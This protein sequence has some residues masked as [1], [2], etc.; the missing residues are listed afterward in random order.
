MINFISEDDLKHILFV[1]KI[2]AEGG[3]MKAAKLLFQYVIGKP[4]ETVDPDRVDVDEWGKLRE[5]S[6]AAE[7]MSEVMTGMPAHLACT[8][9][10]IAW[11]CQVAQ[12]L[13]EPMLAGLAEMDAR[14]AEREAGSRDPRRTVSR[15]GRG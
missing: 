8:M 7:E 15:A 9:A 12:G 2:K 4:P 10:K 13:R 14:D 1:I 6:R 3:D 5:H 11:P